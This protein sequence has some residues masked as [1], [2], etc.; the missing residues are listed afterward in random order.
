LIA[1]IDC[2]RQPLFPV[3]SLL[4]ESSWQL[5]VS[6]PPFAVPFFKQSNQS[7][8][9]KW[10]PLFPVFS[11]LGER[12]QPIDHVLA[13]LCC[14][15]FFLWDLASGGLCFLSSPFLGG[16]QSANFQHLGPLLQFFYQTEI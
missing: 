14:S 15:F 3:F 16:E 1:T 4:G 12:S 10:R 7:I 11:F 9:G 2:K 5:S 6:R 13:P 8:D